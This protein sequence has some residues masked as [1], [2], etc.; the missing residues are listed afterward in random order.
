MKNWHYIAI[1]VVVFATVGGLLLYY[2]SNVYNVPSGDMTVVQKNTT[3]TNQNYEVVVEQKSI[4]V[5]TDEDFEMDGLDFA[6][7]TDISDFDDFDTLISINDD[8][9]EF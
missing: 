3:I 9:V 2:A 1:F 8:V 4:N 6:E 7:G 5:L